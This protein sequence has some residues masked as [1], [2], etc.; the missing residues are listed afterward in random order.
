[1]SVYTRVTPADAER[2]LGAYAVGRLTALEGIPDGIENTNYFLSTDQAAY[3]LTLF[4]RHAAPDLE[5]FL[6]LTLRLAEHGLPC[7]HP[8]LADDGSVL[9]ELCGRPAALVERLPGGKVEAPDADQCAALGAV[10]GRIHRVA[11]GYARRRSNERSRAW[12][13][14]MADALEGAVSPAVHARIRAEIAWQ[15]GCAL[16][17]LPTGV[18]HADLFRDNVLWQGGRL[19]G[20]IDFYAAC[21]DHLLYDVAI[22]VNDWCVSADGGLDAAR[23]RALLA[24]YHAERPLTAPEREAWSGML[25]AAALR[26]WLSRLYDLHFPRAGEITHVKDPAHFERILTART[27]HPDAALAVWPA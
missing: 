23:A 3:V 15:A 5:Y 12:W 16:D 20:V 25:R 9:R 1:M 2:F 27:D 14:V 13:T 11:R 24:A 6:G 8:L 26:F 19:S 21:N 17:A 18:I 7:P 10:L 22:T 4:E